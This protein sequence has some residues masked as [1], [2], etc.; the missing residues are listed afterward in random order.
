[1]HGRWNTFGVK[2]E[3][4]ISIYGHFD[5]L[6]GN[7]ELFK[8]TISNIH[9]IYNRPF[10][11]TKSRKLIM[12]QFKINHNIIYTKEK[13]KKVNLICNDICYLCE[14]EKHTIK[15]MMLKYS[16]VS[17]SFWN[18]FFAWWAQITNEKTNSFTKALLHGPVN[19]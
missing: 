15:H 8:V 10:L 18:E 17:S 11:T 14:R 6:N 13:L 19:L 7:Q 16:Y 3:R 5:I 2:L 1:M 4:T 9:K 12:L